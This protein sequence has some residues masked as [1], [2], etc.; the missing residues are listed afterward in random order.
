MATHS[1]DPGHWRSKAAN[2]RRRAREAASDAAILA[3]RAAE[4]DAVAAALDA[5]TPR[6]GAPSQQSA[7]P[8]RFKWSLIA[9]SAASIISYVILAAGLWGWV[10]G[11]APGAQLAADASAMPGSPSTETGALAPT[12]PAA[13]EAVA[14]ADATP[15][16]RPDEALAPDA[17][18]TAQS[19]TPDPASPSVVQK[20]PPNGESPGA[21][22]ATSASGAPIKPKSEQRRPAA[23]KA[24]EVSRRAG[25][26]SCRPVQS[27]ISLLG[28][29]L[30]VQH[31]ECRTPD[32][33]WQLV[34]GAAHHDPR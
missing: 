5:E 2:F 4:F 10:Q 19:P 9:F 7:I 24:G 25:A 3:K 33:R 17:L 30:P 34:R 12:A 8:A 11:S 1:S 32:G 16:G 14:G 23:A 6:G 21:V 18:E 31:A 26:N 15:A 29:D 28:W 20:S 13:P 22:H 27:K